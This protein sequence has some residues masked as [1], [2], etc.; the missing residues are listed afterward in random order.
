MAGHDLI[1]IVSG[2]ESR[3]WEKGMI[4]FSGRNRQ[5]AEMRTTLPH[6]GS[7]PVQRLRHA[8]F[9]SGALELPDDGMAVVVTEG[10]Y[11]DRT[12]LTYGDLRALQE[13]IDT[14]AS[15][16]EAMSGVER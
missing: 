8:V 9:V 7:D 4:N 11:P 10:L 1:Q 16:T 3:E 13:L 15:G 5:I 14:L 6:P 2:R 12:G